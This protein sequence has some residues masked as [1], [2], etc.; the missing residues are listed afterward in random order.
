MST[1]AT[2]GWLSAVPPALTLVT[3]LLTKRVLSSLLV[4]VLC[5]SLICNLQAPYASF[6]WAIDYVVTVLGK[7]DNLRLVIFSVLVGGLLELMKSSGGFDAF[8]LAL[9]RWRGS[10]GKRTL[11]GLNWLFGSTLI[12]ESWSNVLINGAATGPL[13]DR[14]GI[15]RVRLAYFIHTIGINIVALILINSWGAFYLVL[16][17]AQGVA[18]PL[19]F[20][21]GAVPYFLYCWISLALVAFAMATGLTIGPMR[22]YGATEGPVASPVNSSRT[23]RL[24]HMVLPVLCLIVTVLFGLWSTGH[25]NITAGDGSLSILYAVIFTLAF[26]AVILRIDGVF[27]AAE[28]EKKIVAGS[29]GFLDVGA[30][31][32]LALS[33]GKLTQDL[34]TGPFIAQILRTSLPSVV[35]PALV[36]LLSAMISFSTGTSYGT[37]S[38][39]VPIALPL[40]AATG[41]NQELLF[42]ACIS[43][44]VFGDNSSPISDTTIVASAAA[45]TPV[46]DHARTQLPYALIAAALATFGYLLLAL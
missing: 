10:Y 19:E 1:P 13:Y 43:G 9:Q 2:L 16:V 41:I 12:L 34:G 5:A 4:G 8:A 22:S 25:G 37:F 27:S 42:G 33:L 15:A 23:P 11:F 21:I 40:G 31:I 18:R 17:S 45:G 14:L 35:L 26:T 38:I 29:A 46:I 28:L 44:G 3:A 39:M 20:L 7:P 30:L 24:R 36:F 6:V 32:V